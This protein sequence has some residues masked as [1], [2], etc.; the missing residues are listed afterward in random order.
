[1]KGSRIVSFLLLASGAAF[2]LAGLYPRLHGEAFASSFF[3]PA[4]TLFVLGGAI[5]R[6]RK[7]EEQR[8]GPSDGK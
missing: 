8:G 4:V 5:R 2:L 7:R 6:R 3:A 1:M